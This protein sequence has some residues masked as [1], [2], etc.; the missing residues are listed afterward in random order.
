MSK[1]KSI[2]GKT[3]GELLEEMHE[4]AGDAQIVDAAFIF[5]MSDDLVVHGR[6][7]SSPFTMIGGIEVLKRTVMQSIE[8]QRDRDHG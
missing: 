5:V 4:R 2:Y 6:S 7:G 1:V 8:D 3:A